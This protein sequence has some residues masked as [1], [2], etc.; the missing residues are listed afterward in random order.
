[1]LAAV[2]CLISVSITLSIVAQDEPPQA[3]QPHGS[4]PIQGFNAH[5]GFVNFAEGAGRCVCAQP[6]DGQGKQPLTNDDTLEL[7]DGRAEVVLVPGYYLRLADHTTARLRDLS[8]DNLKIELVKGSI[9][10]EI[11]VEDSFPLPTE[12][13]DLKDRLFN[14]VTVI[15]PSGESAIFKAGAY[16]FDV[17]SP[18]QSRVTVAKGAVAAG[19]HILKDGSS[20]SLTAGAVGIDHDEHHTDDAFDQWSRSRAATLVQLN[21]SLKK[22]DWYKQMEHGQAY[23]DIKDEAPVEGNNAHVVSARNGVTGFVEAGVT[24]KSDDGDWRELKANMGLANKDRVLSAAYARAEILPY[25][26]FTLYVDGNTELTYAEDPDG[27]IAVQVIRGSVGLIVSETRV[28]RAERNTL[29]LSADGAN[30]AITAADYYRLNVF[31]RDES[32]MLVYSGSVVAGTQIGAGKRIVVHGANRMT[33]PLD[34]DRRDSFDFWS[35]RRNVR[36]HLGDVRRRRWHE[37]LWFLDPATSEFTFVPGERVCKSP[38]GGSYSTMYL[39]NQRSFSNRRNSP[40]PE[41]MKPV[42]VP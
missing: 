28:K 26:D 21:K 13:Q 2:V 1:M 10:F 25:P 5:G 27:A 41:M 39:L 7:A 34:K 24:I 3:R 9:I 17:V 19:G 31:S 16:R 15:T 36:S 8:R 40:P 42:G 14:L 18:Q 32:E 37:G 4:I 22:S 12:I 29:R 20:A 35:D 11:P 23:L 33:T 30:Y 6:T 38:S